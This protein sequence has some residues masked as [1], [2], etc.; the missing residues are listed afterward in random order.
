[1][2]AGFW[3]DRDNRRAYLEF[4]KKQLNMTSLED[5]Y[6]VTA[7]VV[8]E[9]GG[10]SWASRWH[11]PN[12]HTHTLLKGRQF[13]LKY[14]GS[15]AAAVADIYPDHKWQAWKFKQAPRNWWASL[16]LRFAAK[17]PDAIQM[18]KQYIEELAAQHNITNLKDWDKYMKNPKRWLGTTAMTHL[19]FI[20]S[21]PMILPRIYPKHNW[22]FEVEEPGMQISITDAGYY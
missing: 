14:K 3:D 4:L 21:L 19:A 13:L 10:A 7:S 20:G 18:V 1:L 8:N 5:F 22:S 12:A 16:G 17:S 6:N 2:V 11:G 15:F 9:T